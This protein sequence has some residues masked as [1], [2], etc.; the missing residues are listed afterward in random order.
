MN[1]NY[2]ISYIKLTWSAG[3]EGKLDGSMP[4]E[5][6]QKRDFRSGTNKRTSIVLHE[7]SFGTYVAEIKWK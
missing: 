5:K 6:S 3:L 7:I 4:A 2:N 1:N